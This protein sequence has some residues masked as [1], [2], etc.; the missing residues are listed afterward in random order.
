MLAPEAITEAIDFNSDDRVVSQDRGLTVINLSYTIPDRPGPRIAEHRLAPL[1][2]SIWSHARQGTAVLVQSA[3]NQRITM[4]GTDSNGNVDHLSW[5]L[6]GSP[7]AI[8]VGAL[9]RN[10]TVK[11]KAM[12]ADY[13]NRA[14]DIRSFQNRFLTVGVRND[15]TGL[16]GTSFAAPIVSGYAAVLGS[17]FRNATPAQISNQLLN[18]A[19]TDTIRNY[20]RNVHGRG[21]ASI[22]RALAPSS[23]R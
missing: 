12:L 5:G 20:R 3:G 18:T 8:F 7:S 15:V 14:G 9:D 4:G 16:R 13:S 6:L 22:A 2:R 19:R 10:G 17:K 23:L 1:H 21:E 11:N